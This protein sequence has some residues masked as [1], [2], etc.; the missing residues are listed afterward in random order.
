MLA[1][2]PL[3]VLIYHIADEDLVLFPLASPSLLFLCLLYR[4]EL[5]QLLVFLCSFL[6]LIAFL[7]L[8]L[9]LSLLRELEKQHLLLAVLL[10]LLLHDSVLHS[11]HLHQR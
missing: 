5:L 9:T 1:P 10:A 8:Q 11:V 3:V 2:L 7:C 6:T 4:E